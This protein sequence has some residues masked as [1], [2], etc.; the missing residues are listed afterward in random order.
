MDANIFT[1]AWDFEHE[2]VSLVAV[3]G[4]AGA[5]L[6]GATVYELEPGARWADLHIHYANEEMIVVLAGTPTLYTLE[7]SRELAP[8]EVAACLRGP[9]GAHRLENRSDETARVMIVSTMLMP[10][11]VEYPE[12][13]GGGGVFVMTEPP[14]TG[15]PYDETRGRILR[16]FRKDDGHPVPPDKAQSS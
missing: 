10:E 4:Q 8:G 16:V 2:G 14:W 5:E 13:P 1:T 15:A 7:G 9:R 12:R 6:L 3:G 11:V